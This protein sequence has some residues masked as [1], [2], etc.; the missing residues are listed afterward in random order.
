MPLRGG[1][2]WRQPFRFAW[3]RTGV[4]A[5]A[6]AHT[7]DTEVSRSLD[8]E[9]DIRGRFAA[10]STASPLA[11]RVRCPS[12]LAASAHGAGM[13]DC[14]GGT[15]G[16]AVAFIVS[17]PWRPHR[18]RFGGGVQGPGRGSLH[19]AA[20]GCTR[21]HLR[22][23]RGAPRQVATARS[24]RRCAASGRV[25]RCCEL[26]AASRGSPQWSWAPGVAALTCCG[27]GR[28]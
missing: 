5:I 14:G 17:R 24:S 9:A 4:L 26:E 27:E 28:C 19:E 25:S 6:M 7:H 18:A 21:R 10:A 11:W 22:R 23:R 15:A 16:R 2:R 20:R 3:P 12:Q 1:A 8:P 13:V